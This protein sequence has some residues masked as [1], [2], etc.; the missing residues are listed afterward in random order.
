MQEKPIFVTTIRDPSTKE[1]FFGGLELHK[2]EMLAGAVLT[3]KVIS[4]KGPKKMKRA[5]RPR[6]GKNR[7]DE[8]FFRALVKV[9]DAPFRLGPHPGAWML[10][11]LPSTAPHR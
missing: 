4:L 5:D 9:R 7:K 3:G 6:G 1:G 2:K 11:S 10:W 8:D